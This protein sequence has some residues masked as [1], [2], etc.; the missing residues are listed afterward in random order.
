MAPTKRNIGKEIIQGLSEAVEIVEGRAKPGSY[1]VHIP[2]EIDTKAIRR[3]RNMTQAQFAKQ[4][5]FT[6]ARIRD[7]EQGRSCP[8]AA[9]RAFLIV[10]DRRPKIDT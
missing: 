6:L 4:Y 9:A 3:R 10:I 1:R 8:N 2:N 5:G 7:W